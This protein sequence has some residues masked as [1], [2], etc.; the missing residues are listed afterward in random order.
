MRHHHTIFIL[1]TAFVLTAITCQG[2]NNPDCTYSQDSSFLASSRIL[3]T[4]NSALDSF[5]Y[6]SRN[7]YEYAYI[8]D[9]YKKVFETSESFEE[10]SQGWEVIGTD[11][12][13]YDAEGRLTL[14]QRTNL[15]LIDINVGYVLVPR[16]KDEY[17][18][19]EV[20]NLKVEDEISSIKQAYNLPW[21]NSY[22]TLDT[23]SA[24]NLRLSRYSGPWDPSTNQWSFTWRRTYFNNANNLRDSLY[25]DRFSS[26]TQQY[27]PNG[28]AFYEY[29]SLGNNTY[30]QF[31]S[32]SN[33]SSAY[34]PVY[35]SFYTYDSIGRQT[36][37][38]SESLQS[39][40]WIIAERE[41][42]IY[43]ICGDVE[44]ENTYT[45]STTLNDWQQTG[46]EDFE[47]NEYGTLISS[48]LYQYLSGDPNDITFA[49]WITYGLNNVTSIEKEIPFDDSFAQ[50]SPLFTHQEMS[51]DFKAGKSYS[52]SLLDLQGRRVRG[53]SNAVQQNMPLHGLTG[54]Y[55]LL[56]VVENGQQ[57]YSQKLLIKE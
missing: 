55:Y 21:E 32:W 49:N 23:L 53:L 2:Q 4:F 25:R 27:E 20:G 37:F 45:W 5:E 26:S 18:Y 33:T 35:K 12:L 1:T 40:N 7:A 39:G 46:H 14:S 38:W 10:N 42:T 34:V 52:V 16:Y 51:F 11:S 57:V 30:Y 6:F 48:R 47:Y 19:E 41:E 50:A 28:R 31:D 44:R 13:V 43:N 29:D 54:G 22:R 24:N 17:H 36:N 8:F 3:R 9:G 56:Q 15:E